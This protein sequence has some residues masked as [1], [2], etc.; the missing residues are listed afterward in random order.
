MGDYALSEV[1]RTIIVPEQEH[2]IDLSAAL[3][4]EVPPWPSS[5]SMGGGNGPLSAEG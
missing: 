1:L 5:T 2:A 3:G 4:I